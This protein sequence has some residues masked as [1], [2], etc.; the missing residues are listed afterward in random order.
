MHGAP[1]A[2]Y[3]SLVLGLQKS[4][5]QLIESS[6]MPPRASVQI[7]TNAC[8]LSHEQGPVFAVGGP[9]GSVSHLSGLWFY[10]DTGE[11][12]AGGLG[13]ASFGQSIVSTLG[14]AR[15]DPSLEEIQFLQLFWSSKL[16]PS[17]APETFHNIASR[18]V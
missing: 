11:V 14:Y 6:Q 10:P 17:L 8:C 9:A 2:G 3:Q 12:V 7:P 18:I 5:A 13:S 1:W 16:K 4:C 15:V